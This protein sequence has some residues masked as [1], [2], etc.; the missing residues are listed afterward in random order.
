MW[1]ASLNQ[2]SRLSLCRGGFGGFD[3]P[4]VG[5][6][7]QCRS[8]TV[9]LAARPLEGSWAQGGVCP[10]VSERCRDAFGGFGRPRA[11]CVRQFRSGTI[12]GAAARPLEGFGGPRAGC[13]R[14][15]R[16]GAIEVL[17]RGLWR[18]RWRRGAIEV[19]PR[20]LWRVQWAQGGVCPAVSERCNR[21]AAARPLEGSVGPGQGVS[22]SFGAVQ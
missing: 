22:G 16:S 4:R 14:Q 19:L 17:S 5:C 3:G 18:V 6:V 2:P 20:G 13:V 21:G 8:G 15:F 1:Y 9:D 12:R 10:A 11:G 7:R